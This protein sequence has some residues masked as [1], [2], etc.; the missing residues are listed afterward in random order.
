MEK[1]FKEIAAQIERIYTL[2]YRWGC[3]T[4]KMIEKS[5]RFLTSRQRIGLC[6]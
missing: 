2:Y 3:G 1:S 6:F 4:K 5:E